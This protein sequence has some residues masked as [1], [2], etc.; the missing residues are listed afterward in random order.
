MPMAVHSIDPLAHFFDDIFQRDDRKPVPLIATHVDVT[1]RGGLGIVTTQRTFR[2]NEKKSIEAA[3]TFPVPVDATLCALTANIDGCAIHA[4]ARARDKA[5]KAYEAAIA[6]GKSAILHQELLKGVHMVSVGH[7]RPGGQIVVTDTWTAPL[8]FLD[9]KPR[10][11]I[12]T[13]VGEIYGRSP[14]APA[15]DLVTG[16]AVQEASVSITCQDG[17][18]SLLNAGPTVGGRCK[19]TLD[20]PIDIVIA[21][22]K[23][24]KLTGVAA[25]GRQVVLDI[26]RSPSIDASL[27]IDLLF[28]RSGSMTTHATSYSELDASKFDLAK[29]GLVAAVR[30]QFRQADRMRLWQFDDHVDYLG[31]AVGPDCAALVGGVDGPRGGTEIGRAFDAVLASRAPTGKPKNVV[32][33]TDGLSWAL[34]PEKLAQ[35]GV[36]VTGVLIGEDA[37]EAGVGHLADLTGG[38]IFTAVGSDAGGAI[39][40][41]IDAARMPLRQ[42]ETVR[43]RPRALEAFRRGARIVATWGPK[44]EG[45]PSAAARQIGATAAML[46]IP[47]ISEASAAKLAEAEGIVC[48]LTSLVLVDESGERQQEL[49]ARRRVELQ[50]PRAATVSSA[51]LSSGLACARAAAPASQSGEAEMRRR[52][53]SATTYARVRSV[54]S[55]DE[56]YLPAF[57]R[58][59]GARSQ[60]SENVDLRRLVGRIDWDADPDALRHGD[61]AGLSSDVVAAIAR[62]ARL[63]EIVALARKLAVDPAIVLIGLMARAARGQSRSAGRLADALIGRVAAKD[64]EAAIA[65]AG[66]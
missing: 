49:P 42:P 21:G 7:V 10:L 65:A 51:R 5:S 46:A 23:E 66:L 9:E 64:L 12:P 56:G 16:G 63:P 4:V 57:L 39:A 47:R 35:S 18:A 8:S 48:H 17:S 32:I 13:T 58:R 19:V 52:A 38:Q 2:N 40:A 29:A 50:I 24:R 1:I 20:A 44:G 59:L 45:H 30:H 3:M 15:D 27:D 22:W 34:E 41:A 25:D 28:D 6:G 43:D 36:R 60:P 61:F 31:G 26:A 11:R 62:A 54:S 53:E 14:L 55:H 37:S 33:V